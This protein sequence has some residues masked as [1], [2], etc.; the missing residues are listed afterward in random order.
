MGGSANEEVD[1]DLRLRGAVPV[2]RYR[3]RATAGVG[4]VVGM[5]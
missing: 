5:G 1:I 4:N 3:S 2:D